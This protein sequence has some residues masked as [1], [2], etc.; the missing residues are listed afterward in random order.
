V[1]ASEPPFP[2]HLDDAPVEAYRVVETFGLGPA[3]LAIALVSADVYFLAGPRRAALDAAEYV[4]LALL[5]A[6]AFGCVGYEVQRRRRRAVL[7]VT[8]GDVGVYR[9][10]RLCGSMSERSMVESG[11]QERASV[12]V[13][14]LLVVVA[15]MFGG[16]G[17][18]EEGDLVSRIL[19][20]GP[21]VYLAVLAASLARTAWLCAG[22]HLPGSRAKTLLSRVALNS[23]GLRSAGAS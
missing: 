10:G 2:E 8:D 12:K 4:V 21:G 9:E 15:I 19:A 14:L 18:T 5:L 13:I 1:F 20:M 16:Y 22:F 11:A 3:L 17:L 6:G 23:A 7:V